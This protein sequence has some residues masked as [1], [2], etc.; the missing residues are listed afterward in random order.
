MLHLKMFAPLCWRSNYKNI[1]VNIPQSIS[2]LTNGLCEAP[3]LLTRCLM[4]SSK[5]YQSI[6]NAKF[7]PLTFAIIQTVFLQSSRTY[8]LN[9]QVLLGDFL[10]LLTTTVKYVRSENADSESLRGIL[11]FSKVKSRWIVRHRAF[12][13][14]G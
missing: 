8:G 14:C 1:I 6:L 11:V 13:F 12:S 9:T 3:G 2:L 7:N 5:L 4:S 10:F